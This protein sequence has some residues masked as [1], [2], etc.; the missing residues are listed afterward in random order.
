VERKRSLIVAAAVSGTLLAASTAYALTGGLLDRPA[1]D[2]AG[3][4]APVTATLED[5]PASAVTT[6]AP[7][8]R[9]PD[10]APA[11]RSRASAVGSTSDDE[12]AEL[13][14]ARQHGVDGTG[15]VYEGADDDD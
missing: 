4:L 14:G 11:T 8:V 2:G 15:P 13:E 1:N 10:V 6:P 7:P 3:T 12:R 9:L 5:A